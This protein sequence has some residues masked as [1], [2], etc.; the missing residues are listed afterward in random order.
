MDA[1]DEIATV[2]IPAGKMP[3]DYLVCNGEKTAAWAFGALDPG[4]L[5][6][7]ADPFVGAGRLIAGLAGPSALKAA[8]I[9][10]VAS[11]KERTEKGDLGLCRRMVIDPTT[12][13]VLRHRGRC[14]R[15][16]IPVNH[17]QHPARACPAKPPKP[18]SG[19]GSDVTGR[20][21]C[22]PSTLGKSVKP[23]AS[24]RRSQ[25]ETALHIRKHQQKH[26]FLK[27]C[28]RSGPAGGR[29]GHFGHVEKPSD[30]R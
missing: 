25:G 14:L 28:L 19:H 5:A 7:A 20:P 8:G 1:H 2:V 21:I 26:M 24:R 10:V 17:G 18:T 22:P 30:R 12:P 13:L 16:A 9:D 23:G 27:M 11:T 4:L 15:Q 3:A 6:E 29:W